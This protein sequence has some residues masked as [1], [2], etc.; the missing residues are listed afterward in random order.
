V[1]VEVKKHAPR[2]FILK[3]HDHGRRVG[4][5]TREDNTCVEKFL[6]HFL[7]FNFLGKGLAIGIDIRRKDSWDNWNGMIMNTT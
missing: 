2:T 7:N 1:G 6:I 4:S 3:G 5:H